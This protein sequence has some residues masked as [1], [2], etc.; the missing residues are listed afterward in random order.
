MKKIV[1]F[2]ELLL[3][4]SPDEQN[5]WLFSNQLPVYMGGAELNTARALAK[6]QQPVKYFTA[7]PDNHISLLVL[8]YL[9]SY[10]IDVSA[11][12]LTGERI[13]LY[14]LP[15]GTD[16]QNAGVIYDR[17]NSSFAT[18]EATKVDWDVLLNDADWFHITAISPAVSKEAVLLC[19]HALK[20]CKARGIT[21]S[22]DLNYRKALWKYGK[23]PYEVMPDLIKFADVVMGNIWSI[24]S[25]LNI[26]NKVGN[27]TDDTQLLEGAKI[28]IASLMQQY[29]NISKVACT[30]RMQQHYWAVM[31]YEQE[32]VVSENYNIADA[33]DRAG[34]GDCFMAA[35]IYG[36]RSSL[37]AQQIINIAASAAVGKLYEKGDTTNQTLD[38]I[39]KRMV[40]NEN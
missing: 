10:H 21:I 39:N 31:Q 8:E 24:E 33:I 2:G 29:P 28:S 9:K 11:V 34:S 12:S 36:L 17:N 25:L 7:L 1:C 27:S 18:L 22:V 37:H 15:Q 3:R 38:D 19:V 13:G 14:Y 16:L 30:F 6:W 4:L 5:E 35:L 20:E 23:Q 40:T 32:L 26:P